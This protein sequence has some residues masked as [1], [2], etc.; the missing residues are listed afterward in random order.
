VSKLLRAVPRAVAMQMLLTGDR[1]DAAE[2]HRVGLVS[3]VVA[4][5]DL[6]ARALEIADRISAN[7]PLAIRSI[8]TLATRT[9]D[10]PLSRSVEL[11]QL[12]WGILRDTHDRVEGR[13]AFAQRREPEYQG[14]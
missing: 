10:L 2:A 13:T 8:K 12:L 9:E 6:L 14:R 1:I 7:G 3:E 11:E 4:S 5:D